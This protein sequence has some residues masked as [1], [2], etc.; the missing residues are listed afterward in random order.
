M[1]IDDFRIE[2]PVSSHVNFE[3]DLNT[4]TRLMPFLPLFPCVL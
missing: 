1:I 4:S 3:V 2:W